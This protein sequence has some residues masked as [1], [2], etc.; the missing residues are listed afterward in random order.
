[1]AKTL[2]GSLGTLL[3]DPRIQDYER[4]VRKTQLNKHTLTKDFQSSK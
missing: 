3:G 1:M 4:L 2:R